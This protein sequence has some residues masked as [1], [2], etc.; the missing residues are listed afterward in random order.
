MAICN[1]SISKMAVWSRRG[2][3]LSSIQ[4][5]QAGSNAPR[6]LAL[7]VAAGA[8]FCRAQLPRSRAVSQEEGHGFSDWRQAQNRPGRSG[9]GRSHTAGVEFT[10]GRIGGHQPEPGSVGNLINGGAAIHRVDL[11]VSLDPIIAI[12]RR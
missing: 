11:I 1:R 9:D 8:G 7:A 10:Y 2:C 12:S 5:Y 6:R 3:S 4:A